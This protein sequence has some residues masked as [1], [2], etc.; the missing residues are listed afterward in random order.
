MLQAATHVLGALAT[1]LVA[2]WTLRFRG[3]LAWFTDQKSLI[4]NWHPVLMVAGFIVLFGEGI[5][6]YRTF[7]GHKQLRK[8]VHL[9]T[10]S[11]ALSSALVGVLAA[12]RFH[13]ESTPPIPNLYSFHSWIGLL[14]VIL[15]A[16]QWAVGFITFWYPGAVTPVRVTVLPWHTFF[17]CF[18]YFMALTS[19]AMGI[20]EKLTFLQMTDIV[21]RYSSEAYLANTLGLSLFLLG[22]VVLYTGVRSEKMAAARE[23]A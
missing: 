3:G 5:L 1:A 14:T 6:V 18:I 20:L 8:A 4:F 23:S 19:A 22:A 7:P 9:L 15:F 11:V 2:A 12:F 17:G 10:H 13:N 21:K 16:V